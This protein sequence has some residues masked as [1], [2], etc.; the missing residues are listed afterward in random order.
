MFPGLTDAYSRPLK[1]SCQLQ[2]PAG[3]YLLLDISKDYFETKT[4]ISILSPVS[5]IRRF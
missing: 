1:G 5:Y 3:L 2:I 4:F